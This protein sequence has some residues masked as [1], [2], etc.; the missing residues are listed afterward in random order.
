[1]EDCASRW[2][3][4]WLRPMPD[5]EALRVAIVDDEPPGRERLRALIAAEPGVIV[6]G[7]YANGEDAVR[8]MVTEP[9][10][11]VF[12]DVQMPGMDGFGVIDAL[13]GAFDQDQLPVIVFVTAYDAYALR[14]FEVSA[15]DYLLKPFDRGRFSDAMRKARARMSARSPLE[16]AKA[17][18]E[19]AEQVRQLHR[20][21]DAAGADR[22]RSDQRFVVRNGSRIYFVRAR[23][24][25]WI[26]GDGNYARLHSLRK[27][28]LVRE[29]LKSIESRLDP[30]TFMRIQRSTIINVDRVSVIEPHSHGEYLVTMCDGAKLTSSRT[31]SSGLRTILK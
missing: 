4:R 7:E 12:L 11:I 14:A 10:D 18:A 27:S 25:D 5:G 29:T 19:L 6:S 23:D 20:E 28:H 24:I 13:G 8:G 2:T 17:F 30:R 16:N 1:M 22:A 3:F 26:E 21:H 31:H 9:P 15:T